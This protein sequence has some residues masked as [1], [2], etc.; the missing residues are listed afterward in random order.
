MSKSTKRTSLDMVI[1]AEADKHPVWK[2]VAL[3]GTE[4]NALAAVDSEQ[5]FFA[6]LDYELQEGFLSEGKNVYIFGS[7]EGFFVSLIVIRT[8]TSAYSA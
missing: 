8:H 7:T 4:L 1:P 2:Q 3:V 6:H 5:W